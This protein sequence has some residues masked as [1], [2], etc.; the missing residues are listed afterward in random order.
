M[1]APAAALLAL[2]LLLAALSAQAGEPVFTGYTVSNQEAMTLAPGVTY[3]RYTLLPPD[4]DAVRGQ[5]VFLLEIGPEAAGTVRLRAVPSGERIHRQ[6]KPLTTILTEAQ[7]QMAGTVLAGVNGDFFDTRAGGNVGWLKSDG[8]WRTAGE[9]PDGWA[10]GVGEDG[11]P[12]LGRPQVT[13]TLTLPDGTALPIDALNGL[14]K[15]V[16]RTDTSPTNVLDARRDNQLVLYTPDFGRET[17]TQSGGTEVTLRVGAVLTD[18]TLSGEVIRVREQRTRGGERL[19][20]GTMVLSAVGDAAEALRTLKAGSM[21]IIHI[22][23]QPPFDRAVSVIGGGRTDGGPLLLEGG[24]PRNLE[25]LKAQAVDAVYFY[26]RH[27]RTAVGFRADGS[28]FLVV[29]EG[30]RSGSYGMTLEMLQQLLLDLDAVDALNLDGG[31][32]STMAI[33]QDGRIR[34]VTHT[35]GTLAQ[36]PVGSAVIVELLK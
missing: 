18:G 17:A 30:D 13:M 10:L 3:T 6:L 15:D 36:T 25:S 35:V 24:Q 32:S 21:V 20:P 28:Y 31:P 16:P 7:A 33:L 12:F 29:V 9:F 2:V 11:V 8:V 34:R 23:A 22:E 26:R 5:R 4:G 19:Q 27:P 1:R 14:R